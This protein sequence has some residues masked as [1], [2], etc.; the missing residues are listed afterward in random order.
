MKW[1]KLVCH[2]RSDRCLRVGAR[3]MPICA[4]CF[5]F[6]TGMATGFILGSLMAPD[7]NSTTLFLLTALAIV[8]M[9]VDGLRQELF[10]RESCGTIRLLTGGLAGVMIGLDIWWILAMNF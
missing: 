7:V 5:G 1:R 8:P 4:R 3:V 9:A 2:G 10:E 6:Y